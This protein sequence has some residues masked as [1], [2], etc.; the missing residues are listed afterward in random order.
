[1]IDVTIV[2]PAYNVENHIKASILSVIN[3]TYQN[4]E[5]IIIND[6]STDNTLKVIEE[7][8]LLDSRITLINQKNS[9]V[10]YAR[11]KGIALAKGQYISFLD[12][13]DYYESLYI[14]LMSKP[15][16][17]NQADMTFCKFKEVEITQDGKN[18]RVISQTPEDVKT[19]L[20]N[21]FT[22]HIEYIPQA[23][24]NMAMMYRL[25]KLKTQN[26]LFQIGSHFAEDSEFVLKAA[27]SFKI[28]FIPEYLYIYIY[29]KDSASR[30]CFTS[31]KYLLEIAAY[32][33]AYNFALQNKSWG[34][35][36]DSYFIYMERLL[37]TTKNRSRRFLWQKLGEKNYQTVKYFLNEYQ[38]QYQTNF[39]VPFKGIKKLSNW[40]KLAILRSKKIFLWSLVPKSTKM[41]D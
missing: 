14:E 22:D 16:R 8:L 29:R 4:W 7:C 25:E 11:N 26:I 24:A 32:T 30:G 3:Q 15:L 10:S 33:R 19:I 23:K 38:K 28:T 9:G 41:Y 39:T 34:L 6:G 1:M 21:S 36:P 18:N 2:M 12:A 17:N 37:F 20:N 35:T 27:F 31:D 13:D 5:L 40:P